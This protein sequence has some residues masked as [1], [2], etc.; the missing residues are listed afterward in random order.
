MFRQILNSADFFRSKKSISTRNVL[1]AFFAAALLFSCNT[2][3]RYPTGTLDKGTGNDGDGENN[4]TAMPTLT[5]LYFE[6]AEA[7]SNKKRAGA[8]SGTS[9]LQLLSVQTGESTDFDPKTTAYKVR[10]PAPAFAVTLTVKAADG[11]VITNNGERP[12][13]PQPGTMTLVSVS[14]SKGNSTSYTIFYEGETAVDPLLET[15]I[16]TS[17]L[18]SSGNAGQIDADGNFDNG[19]HAR[20]VDIPYGVT[21][22][23]VWAQGEDGAFVAY[24]KLMP[25]SLSGG[26]K[27]LTILVS[28]PGKNVGAYILTFKPEASGIP[29]RL[30][31]VIPSPGYIA[32][33]AAHLNEPGAFNPDAADG[34]IQQITVASDMLYAAGNQI[35][36][37]VQKPAEFPF[38]VVT[39]R[40]NGAEFNGL[41]TGVTNG[42][43]FTITVNNGAGYMDKTY[44]FVVN[45]LLIPASIDDN[46]NIVL[47][48]VTG[49][50]FKKRGADGVSGTDGFDKAVTA[51]N[52]EF[53]SAVTSVTLTATPPDFGTVVISGDGAQ[54]DAPNNG[55]EITI[56][57]LS[58]SNNSIIFTFNKSGKL[59]AVYTVF[60]V[61]T[62]KIDAKLNAMFS[63][64]NCTINGFNPNDYKNTLSPYIIDVPSNVTALIPVNAIGDPA[65]LAVDYSLVSNPVDG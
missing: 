30:L 21:E 34:E 42:D 14:D 22:V 16:L 2:D 6:N 18:L 25:V 53:T 17:V 48:P 65:T 41:L 58:G 29:S 64:A 5:A 1:A 56:T 23:S 13:T 8:E 24:D 26:E 19:T 36:I 60:F 55:K 32:I 35:A 39:F 47:T 40:R 43:A 10:V 15:A 46:A 11:L 27:I 52:L 59:P 45:V 38:S 3:I 33:D 63:F 12:F 4:G 7:A 37:T 51:Y 44:N 54:A 50:A 61:R 62:D 20:N 31:D 57:S 49:A 9:V 28:K